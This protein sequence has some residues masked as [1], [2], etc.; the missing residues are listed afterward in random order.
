MLKL[1][2]GSKLVCAP[3]GREIIVDACGASNTTIWCCDKPMR[4][5]AKKSKAKKV[6]KNKAKRK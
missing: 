6:I 3:C 4:P 5:K 1:K 2:K